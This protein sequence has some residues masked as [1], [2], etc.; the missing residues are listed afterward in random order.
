LVVIVDVWSDRPGITLTSSTKS[1]VERYELTDVVHTAPFGPSVVTVAR[2]AEESK[3]PVSDAFCDA[4]FDR[5][6][7]TVA[8][9]GY[10]RQLPPELEPDPDALPEPGPLPA[11]DGPAGLPV[12]DEPPHL[13]VTPAQ[14][15]IKKSVTR[16]AVRERIIEAPRRRESYPIAL[17]AAWPDRS[18][19][20]KATKSG[21]QD[22][23]KQPRQSSPLCRCA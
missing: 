19:Y 8:A 5:V 7:V 6:V 17:L 2:L 4:P 12:L 18:Y 14:A 22:G 13:A 23:G 10:V 11:G 1:A 15:I 16:P 9:V 3:A 21:E 20:E